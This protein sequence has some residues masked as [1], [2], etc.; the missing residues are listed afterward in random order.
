MAKKTFTQAEL[1]TLTSEQIIKKIQRDNYS[2]LTSLGGEKL[3]KEM[4]P[5]GKACHAAVNYFYQVGPAKTKAKKI[6]KVKKRIV[7][8]LKRLAPAKYD[9]KDFSRLSN[10]GLV[11]GFNHPSLGEIL[12]IILMKVDAMGD[13]PMLFPVNLPWYESIAKDYARLKDLGI[14]ITPTITPS[15]WKKLNIEKDNPLY[16][17]ANNL[18]HAFKDLYTSISNETVKNGGIIF[19]APSATRQQTVFKTKAV[20]EQK[21][22]IIPTMSVLA[23]SLITA[24][25]DC[26]FLPLAILPPKN[27]KRGLN[28]FKKYHLYAGEPMSLADIKKNYKKVDRRLE[29]FDYEFHLRIAE[30]LPKQF[31]Y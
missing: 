1:E 23:I 27:Y 13:K 25:A 24:K 11:I 2:L 28:L 6:K 19:V 20:F 22:P 29:G 10:S 31:W 15:T 18:K 7:K 21:E 26:N 12:R 9:K 8:T 17:V 30:K 3:R 14:I 5:V 4:V 16:E